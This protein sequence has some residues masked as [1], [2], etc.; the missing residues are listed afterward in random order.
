MGVL[1][2]DDLRF[3]KNCQINA[4][5]IL[6]LLQLLHHALNA[7]ACKPKVTDSFMH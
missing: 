2:N 4:L 7:T 1:Q 5:Q 3:E 6:P